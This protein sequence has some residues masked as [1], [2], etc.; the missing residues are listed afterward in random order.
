VS[1]I[2]H[3]TPLILTYN[4]APNLRR[5]LERLTWAGEIVILDSFSTDATLAIAREFPQVRVVQRKFD[6]FAGQCNF[7][8]QQAQTDWVL[9]LDADY[10][11]TPELVA[12]IKSL[13]PPTG[14][15]GYA[16]GFRYCVNGHSLRACLYPPRTVL[17]QR[18]LANYQNDGHGHR[19]QVAGKISRLAGYI[20]HDDRKP[21]AH[22]LWAQDRYAILEA[23]KL[24]E[25]MPG[26]LGLPDRIRRKIVLAPSLVFFYT[27]LAQ[28]MILDGWPG[29]YYVFQRTFAEILLSLRLIE[30]KLEKRKPESRNQK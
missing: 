11:L 12:E 13:S 4:E 21:L 20:D 5:T 26:E 3:I 19:V 16:V 15:A 14:V 8:L 24:A 25:A 23:A 28:G 9:S 17:Y 10:V 18:R 1:L 2:D 6:S 22:W 29:W 27:L 7:G 30:M